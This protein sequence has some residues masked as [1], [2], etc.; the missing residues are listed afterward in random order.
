V[1]AT[2]RSRA[3]LVGTAIAILGVALLLGWFV[4]AM[5]LGIVGLIF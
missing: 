2:R 1:R 5:F 3:W 4:V